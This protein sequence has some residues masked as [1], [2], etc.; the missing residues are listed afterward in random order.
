VDLALTRINADGEVMAKVWLQLC[1]LKDAINVPE[2]NKEALYRWAIDLTRKLES[3]RYHRDNLLRVLD[4]EFKK[5][6]TETEP[7]N[8]ALIDL[9]TGAETELEAF[10]MQGK[11]SLDVLVKIF[12]PLLGIKLHSYGNAGGKVAKTLRNNLKGDQ[13]ARAQDLL[14]LIDKDK[15]WIGKWFGSKRDTVTHY[16]PIQSSGFV[17]LPIQDGVPRYAPPVTDNGIAFQEAVVLLYQNLLTFCEDFL[18][19]AVSITFPPMIV[20][21]V[22]PERKRDKEYP[23]RYGM[24]L[25]R[26]ASDEAAT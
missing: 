15:P 10:L 3:V 7:T 21:S 23:R 5:R 11:S 12:V 18:A 25:A 8:V 17:T 20:L 19:L 9:T 14:S 26:P 4:D 16:K 1:D 13:L 22:I 24:Y 6:A 2:K